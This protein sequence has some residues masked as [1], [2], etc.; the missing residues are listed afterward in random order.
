ML[1]KD[2]LVKV[3]G[4]NSKCAIEQFIHLRL[5]VNPTSTLVRTNIQ[6][7]AQSGYLPSIYEELYPVGFYHRDFSRQLL[8]SQ[9]PIWLFYHSSSFFFFPFFPSLYPSSRFSFERL[10]RSGKC[11]RANE[12]NDVY[13]V[14]LYI[15]AFKK[16]SGKRGLDNVVGL[17]NCRDLS[18]L[19]CDLLWS[20]LS[21]FSGLHCCSFLFLCFEIFISERISWQEMILN[22]FFCLSCVYP[23]WSADECSLSI[24][25]SL[26]LLFFFFQAWC[27]GNF[28]KLISICLS[29]NYLAIN[30]LI[31]NDY[32]CSYIFALNVRVNTGKPIASCS[33]F[34]NNKESFNDV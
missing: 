7:F 6:L 20:E 12:S 21:F 25:R 11:Q 16:Q 26:R 18:P 9:R 28:L 14:V 29:P 30:F 24:L 3:G 2:H 10:Y 32:F 1:A 15:D 27:E 19:F 17:Q 4:R 31:S 34:T 33:V 5:A 13:G 22:D 8:V 23:P